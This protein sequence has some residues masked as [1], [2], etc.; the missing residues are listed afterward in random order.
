MMPLTI[1]VEAV[2]AIVVSAHG[3]R[4]IMEAVQIFPQERNVQFT[5]RTAREISMVLIVSTH[6][7]Y[8]KERKK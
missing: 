8:L 3:L 2:I 5:A 1:P 4:K 6:T 7:K